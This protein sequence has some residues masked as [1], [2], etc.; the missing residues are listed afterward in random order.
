MT[1][2]N[3]VHLIKNYHYSDKNFST[4]RKSFFIEVKKHFQACEK[5]CKKGER[6]NL[7]KRKLKKTTINFLEATNFIA[8][9]VSLFYFCRL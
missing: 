5:S 7:D 6:M 1:G 9:I 4:K 2:D 3:V 8:I